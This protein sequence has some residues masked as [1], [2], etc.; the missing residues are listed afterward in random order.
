MQGRN[1]LMGTQRREGASFP[2]P[3]ATL[4]AFPRSPGRELTGGEEAARRLPGRC[5]ALIVLTE[6]RAV[7]ELPRFALSGGEGRP[8]TCG[9]SCQAWVIRWLR[10]CAVAHAAASSLRGAWSG[11]CRLLAVLPSGEPD[12]SPNEVSGPH[13]TWGRTVL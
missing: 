9:A 8:R 6:A 10:D 5:A 4:A 3:R 13:G 7:P 11:S 1:R 2:G 12:P